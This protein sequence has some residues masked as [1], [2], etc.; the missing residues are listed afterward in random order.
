ME[1]YFTQLLKEYCDDDSYPWHMPGHKRKDLSEYAREQ[2]FGDEGQS[3]RCQSLFGMRY[4]VTELPELDDLHAPQGRLADSMEQIKEI[5]GSGKSYYLVNGST[6]GIL[7]AISAVCQRGDTIIMGRHCHK[8]VFHAVALLELRPIYIYAPKIEPW[9][10]NGAVAATQIEDVLRQHPEAKAVI[11][12]SPTYEGIVSDIMAISKVVHKAGAYL[13]VDEAHGAHLEFDAQKI[14][15]AIR[16]DA[17]LVIESLHK[18]LPCY[19]QCAILHIC[20]T[21]IEAHSNIQKQVERY[22][23]VY[24]TSSPS[25]LFVAG[26]ENCIAT[27]DEWRDTHMQEYLERL[28]RYRKKWEGLHRIHLLTFADVQEM[29][30]YAYDETK[31]VFSHSAMTGEEFRNKLE[32]EFGLVMEMASLNYILAISTVMDSEEAFH[33]LDRALWEIDRVEDG[34]KRKY[35]GEDYRSEIR[36]L[37]PDI[38]ITVIQE[39]QK[40]EREIGKKKEAVRGTWENQG[41]R[42]DILPAIAWNL[43]TEDVSLAQAEGRIAGDYIAVY[44]PGSP[45]CVPGE[46]ITKEILDYLNMCLQDALTIYGVHKESL[47]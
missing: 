34:Q 30:V 4:D 13:I 6:C 42:G 2:H 35:L 33:R 5:Y 15:P 44:P 36:S 39:P 3:R 1:R 16:C 11:F 45:I 31:L 14:V 46:L 10:I 12:P 22:L 28:K 25:Y 8:S 21:T 20:K 18:T 43:K 38:K 24:E 29:G 26:M 40:K 32:Q 9:N 27:M 23:D 41:T 17:D 19:T 37:S 7:T 47:E